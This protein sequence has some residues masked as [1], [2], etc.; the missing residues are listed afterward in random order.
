MQVS[1]LVQ[2]TNVGE[3]SVLVK[4]RPSKRDVGVVCGL[5]S[6]TTSFVGSGSGSGAD[7][8]GT[9]GGNN[10]GQQI[11]VQRVM[12]ETA[13]SVVYPMLTRTNYT[14][15]ALVMRVNLQAQG[16]WSA[17]EPGYAEYQDDRMAL[18]AILRAVPPEML[19]TLAVKDTA[20]E[21]W[22]SVKT[23]RV[24]VARVREA[25]AQTLRNEFELIRMKESESVDEFSM[26]LNAIV[27]N[28]RM[29]GDPLEEE[30]VVQKFLRVVPSRFVQVAIAIEQLLDLKTLS[31]EE[32]TGRLRT[33]EERYRPGDND[34]GVDGGRLLLTE[35]QWLEPTNVGEDS[36]LVKLRP[37]KRD[38]GVV[39]GLRSGTTSFVGSGSGSGAD[40]SGTDGGN[41]G[42]QQIIVQRVMKETAG[43]VVYPM[44][45]RTNYTDWALVMRVNLQ[46]QG[47]WSAIEPGYAEYQDDRM[48]LSAILRAVPPEMLPTLAVK[49]TAKEAWESV[50]TMR[51]GV[52]R[53]REAKAQTLRNE[54][55]L[56]RM[57]ESESVDDFSMRLN[58]I[59]NNLRM[60]GDP[61]EEEKVVQKFLRVVPSRFVQVAIAIEQ[62]LDLKTLSIEE[63][64]GR[65]RTV[66]ERYRPGDNDG[67]VDGGRLLLTEEQ[68]LEPTN[69]GEDSVLVKLR[70][71]KRD[72]G[73]V[74]GLRSGTTS[75]VHHRHQV[76]EVL[77]EDASGE[78]K[79]GGRP[80]RLI[81]LEQHRRWE[82]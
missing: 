47:L 21:A 23:M 9:D 74:C 65:L 31:I 56:I 4:L 82:R 63:V 41:N 7:G 24:G 32:V 45:T 80:P 49:D 39:C 12:K 46:A 20:K 53:V 3:D 42:G 10:G 60:L 79:G 28:L 58:A 27:N 66:E 11:I 29:L 18:S 78:G 38:V 81:Y 76:L 2:A 70:P 40:G 8:S 55:E 19:P 15:W 57:K 16:L 72:V 59:V 44:L 67:G 61:L 37:S 43:S 35:E 17:I 51:V 34:G 73:V 25:K 71:S 50:K 64:T 1:W 22:E 62:L 69:V 26:R 13:G 33:V 75:F 36:V 6:G 68:W 30:K 14:D 77:A 5:R 54:F 48:A 52:A